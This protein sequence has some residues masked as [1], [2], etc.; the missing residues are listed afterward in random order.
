MFD[1]KIITEAFLFLNTYR[2][3][4]LDQNR[5]V[6]DI[7]PSSFSQVLPKSVQQ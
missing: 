7:S 4:N 2:T 3:R 5:L 6:T 1:D